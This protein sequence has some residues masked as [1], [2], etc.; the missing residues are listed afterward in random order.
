MAL[1]TSALIFVHAAFACPDQVTHLESTQDYL[2]TA[3][4]T[5][6]EVELQQAKEAF[7]CYLPTADEL[8]QYWFL[9]GMWYY[10]TGQKKMAESYLNQAQL[11]GFWD[12][13]YGIKSWIPLSSS[14]AGFLVSDKVKKGDFYLNQRKNPTYTTVR[15]GPSLAQW[16]T[17]NGEVLDGEIIYTY[18]NSFHY[19]SPVNNRWP[20][21]KFRHYAKWTAISSAAFASLAVFQNLR[22]HNS[23]DLSTLKRA[24]GF[25]IGFASISFI[26]TGLSL[27][28]FVQY[29]LY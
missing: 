15:T 7:S 5:M 27:G 28:F 16:L 6:A 9:Q 25:Q 10:S 29:E 21:L 20:A 8:A 11:D 24:Y 22:I 13:Q 17:P 14:E 12:E 1:S 18:P 26:S 19:L 4:F 23:Q 3:Q 2:L